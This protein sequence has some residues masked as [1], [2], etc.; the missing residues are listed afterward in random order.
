VFVVDPGEPYAVDLVA[1]PAGEDLETAYEPR[2]DGGSITIVFPREVRGSVEVFRDGVEL[3]AGT[4]G[5][6]FRRCSP[7][8][9][10]FERLVPDCDYE[11]RLR[12]PYE[13]GA[14]PD[15]RG[16]QA[17]YPLGTVRVAAHTDTLLEVTEE[18]L[19]ER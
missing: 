2:E 1:M 18:Q 10:T 4:E 15:G 5:R 14:G 19:V 7:D 3:T 17:I 13:P 11:L 6:G 16:H 8:R 9:V 12:G